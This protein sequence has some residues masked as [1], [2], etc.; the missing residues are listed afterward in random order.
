MKLKAQPSN[1][2][3][4]HYLTNKS[5]FRRLIRQLYLKD[6]RG[7]LN[8]KLLDIGCGAGELLEIYPSSVGSDLNPML[9]KYCHDSGHPTV[10]A[11]CTALP[12]VS[13]S[14]D[15]LVMSNLLEHLEDPLIALKEA[16]RLLKAGGVLVVTVPFEAGF[17][18]DPT[19]I[20]MVGAEQ[21]KEFA[22]RAELVLEKLYSFPFGGKILGKLLYF[23]ELRAVLRKPL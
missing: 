7:N 13:G 2:D 14:Y 5:W 17:K 10:I 11:D 20:T 22:R 8:G 21:L 1:S 23:F 9:V 16:A 12:L 18:F 4:F 3:Y 6:I 15:S 19:H